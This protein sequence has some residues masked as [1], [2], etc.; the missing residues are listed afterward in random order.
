VW[1]LYIAAANAMSRTADE[2][3]DPGSE[4]DEAVRRLQ[5]V[6]GK[7]GRGINPFLQG[8]PRRYLRTWRPE[9]VLGHAEMAGHLSEDPVQLHLVRGRHWYELTVVTEDRPFLFAKIAGTLAAWGMNIVKADAF[10]NARGVVVDTFYFTD[11]FR[12]LE[13]NASEWGRFERSITDVLGGQ[14]DLDRMLADR[15]RSES[16]MRA[17]VKIETR[18][19]VDDRCSATSTLL[20]VIA[21]DRLGLLY[22]IAS[23][24]SHQ[25]LNIEIALIDTEGQMAVDVFYLTENGRKLTAAKQQELKADLLEEL[26][27]S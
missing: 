24:F 18:V 20:E 25:G 15:R 1:Q 19:E 6:A 16:K 3:L 4:A 2:R 17:R 10:S 9:E 23:R 7:S 27:E 8:L 5:A 12:T 26:A 21:Q 14:A 22:R 13:L 11:R